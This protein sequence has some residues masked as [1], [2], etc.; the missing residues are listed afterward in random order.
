MVIENESSSLMYD[1]IT[2]KLIA[3]HRH[4]VANL[5]IEYKKILPNTIQDN[6]LLSSENCVIFGLTA[7]VP[8]GIIYFKNSTKND[9]DFSIDILLLTHQGEKEAIRNFETSGTMIDYALFLPA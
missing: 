9:N 3:N 1:Q 7:I 4:S 6:R 8:Y 5:I 2:I